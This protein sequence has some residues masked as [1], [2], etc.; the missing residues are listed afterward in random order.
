[1]ENVQNKQILIDIVKQWVTLD[2][3]IRAMNKKLKELRNDKKEQNE[4]MIQVMKQNEIDNFDL[5]DGQIRYKKETKR[6]PLTQ[7]TLLKILSKHP[8]LEQEQ[9]KHLNQFIYDNRQ[10]SEREVVVRKVDED[11]DS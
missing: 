8:Q 10:V 11:S 2:N 9:A 5:K 4:K 3:Q 6:E 7:K 1:M